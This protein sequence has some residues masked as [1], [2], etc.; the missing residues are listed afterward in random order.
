MICTII[1]TMIMLII[2]ITNWF[3]VINE[4]CYSLFQVFMRSD[5]FALR[6]SYFSLVLYIFYLLEIFLHWFAHYKHDQVWFRFENLFKRFYLRYFRI[7]MI[8][9]IN[10]PSLVTTITITIII[11]HKTA[12][13][14][15]ILDL[16]LIL[17]SNIVIFII[18]IHIIIY[19]NIY[20]VKLKHRPSVRI[21]KLVFIAQV[22][23]VHQRL[24]LLKFILPVIH[25]LN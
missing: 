19:I 7:P 22:L 1:I 21:P 17:I 6:R 4:K 15:N 12:M 10:Q 16:K 8:H 3:L 11:Q 24:F 13:F 23:L 20:R 18:I 14:N 25:S 5:I 2:I 9:M